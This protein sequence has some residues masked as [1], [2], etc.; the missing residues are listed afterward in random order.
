VTKNIRQTVIWF[1]NFRRKGMLRKLISV[2][3][4]AGKPITAGTVTIVPMAKSLRVMIPGI[5]GGLIWN[6]PVAVVTKTASGSEH[7][8][9]V[10]DP[11]RRAVLALW[12]AVIGSAL[13]TLAFK[14]RR[15]DDRKDQQEV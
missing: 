10:N 12:G 13:F 3:T 6:R 1:T 8:L 2:E 4:H 5:P 7:V 15:R 14:L 11:T 9:S